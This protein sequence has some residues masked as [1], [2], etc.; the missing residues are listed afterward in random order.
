MPQNFALAEPDVRDTWWGILGAAQH[1]PAL[2]SLLGDLVTFVNFL[3][4][5]LG[6]GNGDPL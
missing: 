2:W 5:V 4:P 6:V 3:P 1:L